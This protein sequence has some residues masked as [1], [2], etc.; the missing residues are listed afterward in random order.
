[1]ENETKKNNSATDFLKKILK[2]PTCEEVNVRMN[3]IMILL[4]VVVVITIFILVKQWSALFQTLSIFIAF[5]SL[6]Y[7]YF[8]VMRLPQCT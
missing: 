4:V 2:P 5:A 6:S 1:M 3:R 7:S 8:I